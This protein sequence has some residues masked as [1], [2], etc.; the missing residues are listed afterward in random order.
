MTGAIIIIVGMALGLTDYFIDEQI[1][2]KLFEIVHVHIHSKLTFLFCLN[3]FLIIV[4]C[5][6]DVF[7]ACVVI[8]PIILPI[9]KLYGVDP[10]HLGIIFLTNLELGFITPPV[11]I[12]LFISSLKFDKSYISV[13]H[14]IIPFFIINVIGLL[15]VTYIPQLSLF[16]VKIFSGKELIIL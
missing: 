9:A 5:L 10:V 4:G 7:S 8:V 13:V 12:S 15:L 3:I 11:G 6:M 16:L 2:Q 14:S 1:P